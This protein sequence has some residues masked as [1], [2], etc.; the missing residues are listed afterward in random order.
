VR[1]SD[2]Y[3]KLLGLVAPWDVV[4]VEAELDEG[5]VVVFVAFRSDAETTCPECGKSCP[6]Y[7]VR[8]RSWRHLDTMQYK[9][10]LTAEVPRVQCEEHGVRQVKVP[11]GEERSRFTALFE[12]LVIDWLLES[13]VSAVA[14]RMKLSWDEVAGIQRRAVERGLARKKAHAPALVG[15][16]E[17]SFQKRHEYV[18]VVSDLEE[19][20]V[21]HV[22]DA[23]TEKSL[24]GF[25]EQL[26][27]GQRATIEA[28][29]MDMH[30]PY[31]NATRAALTN[32]DARIVFDR[33]HVAKQFGDAVDQIRRAESKAL[34]AEGDTRLKGTRYAWLKSPSKFTSKAWRDFGPLRHSNLKVARAW[35][36]KQTA[37]DLWLYQ[38]R[39]WAEKAW[40]KLIGWMQRSR[41]QPM[42]RLARTLRAHFTGLI[43]AVT[44]GV[45]NA[46]AEG[47]NSRIQAIKKHA[48]GFRNRDRF[49]EAIYFRLGGLD[50]YPRPT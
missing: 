16:D 29:A 15:V 10:I 14:R 36:M 30:R 47:I 9:T 6:R 5:Q 20:V 17:T 18:T 2:L 4:D 25:F 33:F 35:A 48:Y 40:K 7:D 49:R 46:M 26:D 24:Q 38:R 44:A 22:A 31:I 23:R 41:L 28:V 8:R 34:I 42:L 27:A 39:S 43:N 13:N 12:C 19:G 45:T 1:D 50:L 37:A 32:A 3:A 11:W 21:L